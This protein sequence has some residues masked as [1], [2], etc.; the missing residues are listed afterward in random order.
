MTN[1]KTSIIASLLITLAFTSC[2]KNMDVTPVTPSPATILPA[3]ITLT[4][5]NVAADFNWSTT[6]QIQ[7]NFAGRD[8][9]AHNLLLKVTDSEG[10]VIMQK[11]QKSDQSFQ[12]NL[13]VPSTYTTLVVSYGADTKNIYCTGTATLN[14]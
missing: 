2:T 13:K 6:K 5:A 1:M 12:T 4:E 7:L 11:M 3:Q 8:T 14:Y 9:Q 10:N